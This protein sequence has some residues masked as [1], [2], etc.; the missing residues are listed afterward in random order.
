M[1]LPLIRRTIRGTAV[2]QASD[3]AA[4]TS[5]RKQGL[6]EGDETEDLYQLLQDV[7]VSL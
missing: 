5:A 1:D 3:Y 7:L 2:D 6:V 4:S